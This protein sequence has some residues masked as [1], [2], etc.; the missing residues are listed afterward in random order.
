MSLLELDYINS[1]TFLFILH[2]AE[3]YCSKLLDDVSN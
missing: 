3:H 1:V 2:N